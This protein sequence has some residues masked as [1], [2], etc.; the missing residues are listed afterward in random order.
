MQGRRVR[1][2]R[3]IAGLLQ[4]DLAERMGV[5]RQHL[6]AVERGRLALSPEMAELLV[7]HL[8][9]AGTEV[10]PAWLLGIAGEDVG[11]RHAE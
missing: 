10:S 4:S 1:A 2:A 8:R 6:G 9:A 11:G 5:S 3:S 7:Q